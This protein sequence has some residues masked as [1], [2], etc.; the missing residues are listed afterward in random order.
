[1]GSSSSKP[2]TRFESLN[3]DTL[4]TVLEF[5]G[6]RSYRSF[7]GVN[8]SCRKVYLSSGMAK[9]TF[10][11]GYGPLSAMKDKIERSGQFHS[12][13]ELRVGK[14]VVLYNRRD[15]LAMVLERKK[16]V[17]IGIC[18]VAGEEGRLDI[19]EEVWNNMNNDDDKE[20]IFSNVDGHAARG[21][22]LDVL[23]WL[24]TKGLPINKY[25]GCARYASQFG[26]LHI[27][28]SLQEEQTLEL[29]GELYDWAIEGGGQLHVMK[30]LKEQACPWGKCTFNYAAQI[31]NLDVLQW[32]HEEGCPWPDDRLLYEQDVKLEVIEWL[33]SSG[34][35]GRIFVR[36]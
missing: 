36:S 9:E 12:E 5:V 14:A 35:G 34:Y 24:E 18:N 21:G 31:G 13:L 33:R 25:N 11:Y 16:S 4:T 10:L 19:L 1:M 26:Q 22:K 15:V 8:K 6:R 30:W 29:D 32:L 17:S 23:K 2:Q 7:G 28:Q 27:L 3:D 20:D